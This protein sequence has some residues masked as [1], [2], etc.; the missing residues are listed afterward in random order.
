M[1]QVFKKSKIKTDPSDS[2]KKLF[3]DESVS[4]LTESVVTEKFPG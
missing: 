4:V 2:Y 1:A 3:T